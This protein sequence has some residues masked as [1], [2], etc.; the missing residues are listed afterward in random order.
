MVNQEVLNSL[1]KARQP[2]PKKEKKPIAKVSKKRAKQIEQDKITLE[3]DKEFYKEVYLASP[4]ACQN[5][6]CKLPKEPSNFM[7]HH[8][9]EK[10]NY[11]QFRYTPENIMILCLLC[12]SKVETNSNFTPKIRKRRD[13]VQKILLNE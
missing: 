10:R 6:G 9:L 5:C 3:A 13:E 8:L 4:H 11:P 7:F 12:H 2:K 1:L